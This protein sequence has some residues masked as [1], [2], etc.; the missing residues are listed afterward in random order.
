MG[1]TSPDINEV[2]WDPERDSAPE[3]R[4]LL[5]EL[6]AL[7][8]TS[9]WATFIPERRTRRGLPLGERAAQL[10][11]GAT[12]ED[13]EVIANEVNLAAEVDDDDQAAALAQAIDDYEEF[14]GA[15]RVLPRDSDERTL[16]RM[17]LAERRQ[18]RGLQNLIRHL[19]ADRYDWTVLRL[20]QAGA[21]VRRYAV[22][23]RSAEEHGDAGQAREY[24]RLLGAHRALLD[25]LRASSRTDDSPPAD[26]ELS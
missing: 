5:C 17:P 25:S 9:H 6:D 8:R 18:A 26:G 2:A 3:R 10:L 23:V 4:S 12:T 11:L 24:E 16:A 14:L 19:Q 15:H 22:L 21:A 7:P 1:M 20:R 13:L